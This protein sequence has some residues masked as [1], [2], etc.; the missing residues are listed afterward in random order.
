MFINKR[1]FKIMNKYSI[2]LILTLIVYLFI[3]VVFFNDSKHWNGLEN[4][5][6]QI[7]IKLTNRLYFLSTS[8]STCGYGDISP[9]TMSAKLVVISMQFLL[10]FEVIQIIS[11]KA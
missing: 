8:F 10:I 4:E 3:Y 6:N 9:K 11:S 7:L 1:V 5:K 2:Y